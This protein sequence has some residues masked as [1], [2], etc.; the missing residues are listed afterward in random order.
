MKNFEA[1]IQKPDDFFVNLEE[2]ACARLIDRDKELKMLI[3]MKNFILN[4]Q[5]SMEEDEVCSSFYVSEVRGF[6]LMVKEL[7]YDEYTIELGNRIYLGSMNN[8]CTVLPGYDPET[9][10]GKILRWLDPNFRKY[11][12][13]Q[14]WHVGILRNAG[15]SVD[16]VIVYQL[17][18]KEW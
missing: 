13:D 2:F 4:L 1:S 15:N 11:L 3:V 6:T 8:I 18:K 9:E 17:R 16:E 12:F 10:N 14:G 5:V 7:S